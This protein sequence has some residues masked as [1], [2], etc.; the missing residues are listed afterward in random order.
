[1]SMR[2]R[3][4]GW[5]P[6]LSRWG[7]EQPLIPGASA[8][9][10]RENNPMQRTARLAALVP[11]QDIVRSRP[12][13]IVDVSGR[14]GHP[15]DPVIRFAGGETA[16]RVTTTECVA[17]RLISLPDHRQPLILCQ[18]RDAVLLGLGELR[19][20]ARTG[21]HV[22]RLLRHR[23]RRLGSQPLGH[24]PWLRRASSFPARR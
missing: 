3:S 11:A 13:S 7:F 15:L 20:G 1:M 19:A 18:H 9:K 16:W 8:N 12:G 21:H 14:L 23:A 4:C 5:M 22:I 6:R 2:R 10:K 17:K 24:A